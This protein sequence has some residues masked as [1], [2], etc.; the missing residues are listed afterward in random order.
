MGRDYPLGYDYYRTRLHRAFASQRY[1]KDEEQIKKGIRRAEFVKK[2][3]R[4]P[5]CTCKA[6]S[7]HSEIEALYDGQ[8]N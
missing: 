2:G 6:N 3:G 4:F 1:L 7:H 5:L 8:P